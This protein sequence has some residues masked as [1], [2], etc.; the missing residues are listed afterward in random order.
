MHFLWLYFSFLNCKGSPGSLVANVPDSNIIVSKFE[1]QSHCY[2]HFQTNTLR[3][4]MYSFILSP[5]YELNST[6]AVFLQRQLW[7]QITHEGWYAIKTNKPNR[8]KHRE[9]KKKIIVWN[10]SGQI[11]NEMPKVQDCD[12]LLNGF[13]F[14]S[15]Y[16]THLQTNTFLETYEPPY[17]PTQ[18]WV[19]LQHGWHWH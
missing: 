3:R 13:E 7:Y 11:S 10:E 18:L 12:I 14:Q 19:E 5:S 6:T 4:G 16:Y 8:A 2:V 15:R 1:P 9:K 17:P